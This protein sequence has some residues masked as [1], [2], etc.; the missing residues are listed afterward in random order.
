MHLVYEPDEL[1]PDK[2]KVSWQPISFNSEHIESYEKDSEQ[3]AVVTFVSGMQ[4]IINVP[5]ETLDR[6]ICGGNK[7][8]FIMNKVKSN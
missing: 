5:Y 7:S 1:L 8:K 4:I 6:A 2:P 3:S